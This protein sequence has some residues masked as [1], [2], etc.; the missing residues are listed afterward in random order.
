[1]YL[2]IQFIVIYFAMNFKQKINFRQNSVFFL[3]LL[4]FLLLYPD[5]E[6]QSGKNK[7]P[8]L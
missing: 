6:K 3:K 8:A 1:M 7:L 5:R 4:S 2:M